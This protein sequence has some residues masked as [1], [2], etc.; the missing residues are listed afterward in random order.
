MKSITDDNLTISLLSKLKFLENNY[1][2]LY[3]LCNKIFFLKQGEVSFPS[4]L[5]RLKETFK[6]FP[7][8]ECTQEPKDDIKKTAS[9]IYDELKKILLEES[10][11][12]K[13]FLVIDNGINNIIN[14]VQGKA[15]EKQALNN[16]IYTKVE[17]LIKNSEKKIAMFQKEARKLSGERKTD[18]RDLTPVRSTVNRSISPVDKKAYSIQQENNDLKELVKKLQLERDILKAWKENVLKLPGNFSEDSN[19]IIKELETT[20]KQLITQNKV[21][22][23]RILTISSSVGKFLKDTS[24]FQ[25]VSR[26]KEGFNSLNFYENEKCKLEM[27]IKELVEH[28]ESTPVSSPLQSPSRKQNIDLSL[29]SEK[30]SSYEIENK[31]LKNQL[32][33]FK[34]TVKTLEIKCAE[35]ENFRWQAGKEKQILEKKNRYSATL[36][37][38]NSKKNSHE[39]RKLLDATKQWAETKISDISSELEKKYAFIQLK[40][41]EKENLFNDLRARFTESLKENLNVLIAMNEDLKNSNSD[42]SNDSVRVQLENLE[43]IIEQNRVYSEIKIQELSETIEMLETERNTFM[44]ANQF[45]EKE[46]FHLKSESLRMKELENSLK[47]SKLIISDLEESNRICNGKLRLLKQKELEV[48]QSAYEKSIMKLE[49]AKLTEEISQKDKF[50]IELQQTLKSEEHQANSYLEDL[51]FKEN[52]A[53]SEIEQ[54][55]VDI[56]NYK[57]E[58]NNLNELQNSQKDQINYLENQILMLRNSGQVLQYRTEYF[59]NSTPLSPL[60]LEPFYTDYGINNN[61]VLQGEL[62]EEKQTNKKYSEQMQLLKEHIRDLEKQ[63]VKY[64]QFINEETNN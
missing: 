24:T 34:K 29:C 20:K 38:T 2:D 41:S 19:T 30:S 11:F 62:I 9:F 60:H 35:L 23:S 46:N 54:L 33:D 4:N 25:K 47:T 37:P 36:T 18:L 63:I 14:F 22:N 27:K 56:S 52:A 10:L 40:L 15:L 42:K 44:K 32:R 8:P 5:I 7:R 58:I 49:I 45:L 64:K 1:S 57:I 6:S 43:Y 12:E 59:S 16:P 50:I 17:N 31:I 13:V 51:V 53:K 48:E 3:T 61:S 55:K 39:Y 28:K 21:L 26:E